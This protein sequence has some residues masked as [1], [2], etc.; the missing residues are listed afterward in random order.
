MHNQINPQSVRIFPANYICFYYVCS[1]AIII[2]AIICAIFTVLLCVQL[3]VN[4]I[5]IV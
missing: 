5:Y 2:C 4:N 1:Y 3:K